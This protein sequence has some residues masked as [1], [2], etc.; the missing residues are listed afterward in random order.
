MERLYKSCGF[1]KMGQRLLLP[2]IKDFIVETN[3]LYGEFFAVCWKNKLSQATQIDEIFF[4]LRVFPP[5]LGLERASTQYYLFITLC[6]V[7]IL[8]ANPTTTH[9]KSLTCSFFKPRL[10]F[11]TDGCVEV[12]LITWTSTNRLGIS[13]YGTQYVS[14]QFKIRYFSEIT[15]KL[16]IFTEPAL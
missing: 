16:D 9:R 1:F 13:H 4:K 11:T 10:R 7:S 2:Q 15:S 6:N 3:V 12:L 14:E 5:P 8:R